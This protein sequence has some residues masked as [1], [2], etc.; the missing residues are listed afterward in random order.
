MLSF[1]VFILGAAAI[2]AYVFKKVV[3]KEFGVGTVVAAGFM[4]IGVVGVTNIASSI[5]IV[6][7]GER[8]VVF[9]KFNGVQ[10]TALGEGFHLIMPFVQSAITYDVR[11]QKEEFETTAASRDLQDVS[12][13][14]TL[15]VHPSAEAV[16]QI[17]QNYGKDYSEKVIHP[18]VQ[19]AVK[20]V[21]ALYTAEE[22]ITK[23]EAVKAQVQEHLALLLKKADLVLTETYITNFKFS[24]G[25]A[26]AIEQK[27]IAEQNALTAQ[28][29]LRQVKTEAEQQVAKAQAEAAGLR[30]QREVITSELLEL[31]RIEAQVKA[32]SKWDGKLPDTIMGGGTIPFINVQ[33]SKDRSDK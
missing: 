11:I 12:T 19:E 6:G 17:Y 10:K 2:A 4:F 30:A 28:N 13:K 26:H 9:D 20:A 32:I 5:V 24:E 3:G 15:N 18:A 8:V 33:P 27:Q 25:F 23:R 16:P 1:L 14:V 7:A 31:R 22:L 21:T 29:T